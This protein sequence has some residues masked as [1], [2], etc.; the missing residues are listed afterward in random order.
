MK[1]YESEV[2]QVK[3]GIFLSILIFK[4]L[5]SVFVCLEGT[6]RGRPLAKFARVQS[7]VSLR[8]GHSALTSVCT[9]AS[10]S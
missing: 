8:T 9:Q 10:P 3:S 2:S 6:K 5:K 7:F 4:Y 1:I